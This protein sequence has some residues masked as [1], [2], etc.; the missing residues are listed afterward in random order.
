MSSPSE[1]TVLYAMSYSPSGKAL[2]S[3][4]HSHFEGHQ[5]QSPCERTALRAEQGEKPMP[6][7]QVSFNNTPVSPT[8]TK[9]NITSFSGGN[10]SYTPN[11]HAARRSEGLPYRSRL[12]DAQIKD[13]LQGRLSY[14]VT[15]RRVNTS[16]RPADGS[17]HTN[18]DN[19]GQSLESSDADLDLTVELPSPDTSYDT[20]GR[21]SDP[22]A[23]SIDLCTACK[24]GFTSIAMVETTD[25]DSNISMF[26]HSATQSASHL[27]QPSNSAGLNTHD[28]SPPKNFPRLLLPQSACSCAHQ[29]RASTDGS[30]L[31][32][33]GYN[34]R[35]GYSYNPT[36][37][38]NLKSSPRFLNRPPRNHSEPMNTPSTPAL[39]HGDE[40]E[41]IEHMEGNDTP[42]TSWEQ[43]ELR[44]DQFKP[45]GLQSTIQSRRQSSSRSD[46]LQIVVNPKGVLAEPHRPGQTVMPSLTSAFSPTYLN[47]PASLAEIVSPP[48]INSFNSPTIYSP[49]ESQRGLRLDRPTE[50]DLEKLNYEPPRSPRNRNVTAGWRALSEFFGSIGQTHPSSESCSTQGTPSL[51]PSAPLPAES[52]ALDHVKQRI[53]E[54]D[55]SSWAHFCRDTQHEPHRAGF[56]RLPTIPTLQ[57]DSNIRSNA[58]FKSILLNNN[59]GPPLQAQLQHLSP[60]WNSPQTLDDHLDRRTRTTSVPINSILSSGL[61][62]EVEVEEKRNPRRISWQT[63]QRLSSQ[64]RYQRSCERSNQ[65][66]RQL[67]APAPHR[68]RHGCNVGGLPTIPAIE[69]THR[70]QR[71]RS[72]LI[73]PLKC[74]TNAKLP[75]KPLSKSTDSESSLV[76]VEGNVQPE[77]ISTNHTRRTTLGDHRS[78]VLKPIS[79]LT[80][81]YPEP[82]VKGWR[83][84]DTE[85]MAAPKPKGFFQSL[86]DSIRKASRTGKTGN[87]LRRL[88]TATSANRSATKAWLFMEMLERADPAAVTFWLGCLFG[89]WFFVIG[90][91]YLSPRIGEIG[92]SK[93]NQHLRFPNR[94]KNLSNGRTTPISQHHSH[95]NGLSWVNANRVAACV[96]GPLVL[97]G[98]IW[99]LVIVCNASSA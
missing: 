73:H 20:P 41:D 68:L 17:P 9:N 25:C 32:N 85:H 24:T 78:S 5:P 29:R 81:A 21:P 19:E 8:F 99:S 60:F 71:N 34:P 49:Q 74:P 53:L 46:P 15:D 98:F 64:S 28:D 16:N 38:L 35:H 22:V 27:D 77:S 88:L 39:T 12:W 63:H 57:D 55:R 47:S 86:A 54:H 94:V 13:S 14:E 3:Y 97:G 67:S 18:S 95:H 66:S 96:T 93:F 42:D 51:L 90:G 33:R 31:S 50:F 65:H 59:N 11:Q 75:Q 69:S 37:P 7:C 52:Q 44:D 83:P 80:G 70:S 79:P 30:G 89:P 91:W 2:A 43:E 87:G 6:T 84:L 76:L 26:I 82:I 61:I 23:S 56:A 4:H 45:N 58:Q 48:L 36:P 1:P 10:P 62:P 92:Q 72:S 40:D